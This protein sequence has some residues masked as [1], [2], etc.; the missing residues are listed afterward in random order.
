MKSLEERKA[1]RK[2]RREEAGNPKPA[3]VAK[4]P[5]QELSGK[6]SGAAKK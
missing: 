3:K 1:A 2:K 5:R 4:K 6:G